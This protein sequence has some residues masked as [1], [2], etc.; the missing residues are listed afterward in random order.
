MTLY[1][2]QA[3]IQTDNANRIMKRLCKHW[4]H[5]LKIEL[6]DETATIHFE[7]AICYLYIQ[8]AKLISKISTPERAILQ[9]MQSV[10]EDHLHRM[11]TPEILTIN[12]Q[13]E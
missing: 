3:D 7:K 9:Q 10:V 5:K 1:Q 12:W 2:V 4:S 8:P 11:A 13:N 6:E